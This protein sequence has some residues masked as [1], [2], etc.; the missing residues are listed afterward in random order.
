MVKGA[1]ATAW[2]ENCHTAIQSTDPPVCDASAPALS[3]PSTSNSSS[4]GD[5][6]EADHFLWVSIPIHR[7]DSGR[8]PSLCGG[9]DRIR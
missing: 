3:S 2:C 5:L 9:E 8:T 6:E 7:R 1:L 4:A